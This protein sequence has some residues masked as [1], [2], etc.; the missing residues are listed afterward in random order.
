[1]H[2]RLGSCIVR[3]W[4]AGDLDSLVRHADN[5]NIWINLRDRFPHPYTEAD[6]RGFLSH[7][8][9]RDAQTVWAI[10]VD[11]DAVGGI[12]LVLMS[13]VERVSAEIGYW[14]GEAF[15]SRG[16]MTE[17]VNAVTSEAFRQFELTRIFAL[18]FADNPGS[19]RV[20]EKAGYVLEGRLPQSAIKN[21]VI[22][23]QLQFGAYKRTWARR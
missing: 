6:G 5:W 13:D 8:T 16:V 10:E 21:G 17:A 4:A 23:D 19:I 20:L 3:D 9:S 22:R 15:W 12:G 7:V 1:V 14:L 18:P 11:G 2:L